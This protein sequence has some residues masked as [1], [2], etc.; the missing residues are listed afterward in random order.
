LDDRKYQMRTPL[1]VLSP[2]KLNLFLHIT[3]R[4]PDGY[5]QL[6]TLFQLLAWGDTMSFTP[7]NRGEITLDMPAMDIPPA[8]NL[9][10]RAARKLRRN[11]LGVHIQVDKQIPSGSGLGGGSSNAAT[12]LLVL[13]HPW[14]RAWGQ[15]CPFLSLVDRPGQRG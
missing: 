11:S 9:I 5:H 3:G 4:R 1:T 7:N 13:N 6:Q 14:E 8:E 10:L 15:M 12:T 2:A